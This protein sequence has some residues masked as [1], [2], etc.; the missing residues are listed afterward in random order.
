MTVFILGC[1]NP[2]DEYDCASLR[3]VDEQIDSDICQ[4]DLECWQSDCMIMPDD[5]YYLTRFCIAIHQQEQIL[6]RECM[7]AL[8]AL[9]LCQNDTTV[10]CSEYE[11]CT[12]NST[13]FYT[14]SRC[15]SEFARWEPCVHILNGEI[16]DDGIDN[17]H[18]GEIDEGCDDPKEVSCTDQ[19]DN[20][21]DGMTDCSD[22]DCID[23]PYCQTTCNNNG[24][25]EPAMGENSTNCFGDCFES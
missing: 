21:M 1:D 5:E 3:S 13:E 11:D 12:R 7:D 8:V 25:C 24:L 20:D 2:V 10:T 22:S 23:S 17:D 9:Y 15:A 4:K 16:C 14:C 18:N 6:D 19:L